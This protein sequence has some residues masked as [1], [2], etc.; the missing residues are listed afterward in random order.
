MEAALRRSNA[1]EPM[2]CRLL[3]GGGWT[4][5]FGTAAGKPGISEKSRKRPGRP[6]SYMADA[7]YTTDPASR[8]SRCLGLISFR[9]CGSREFFILPALSANSHLAC[10]E[11]ASE[12]PFPDDP[13]NRARHHEGAKAGDTEAGILGHTLPTNSISISGIAGTAT[14]SPAGATNT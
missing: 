12:C 5:T 9:L 7:L 3:A 4:R 6:G 2:V 10:A 11:V 1:E 13:T 14:P 8:E